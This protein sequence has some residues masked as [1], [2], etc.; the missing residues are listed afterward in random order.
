MNSMKNIF[1]T[2]GLI[3]FAAMTGYELFVNKTGFTSAGFIICAMMV[4]LMLVCRFVIVTKFK[5]ENR[6]TL[7][8]AGESLKTLSVPCGFL[9]NMT[10]PVSALFFVCVILQVAQSLVT[11]PAIATTIVN[12]VTYLI[13]GITPLVFALALLSGR[14]GKGTDF[15]IYSVALMLYIAYSYFINNMISPFT[16]AQLVFALSVWDILSG[17][18]R[19]TAPPP[20]EKKE[21]GKKEKKSKKNK[22]SKEENEV[23]AKNQEILDKLAAEAGEKTEE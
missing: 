18:M 17:L 10:I 20:K 19:K 12:A 21:K 3:L 13:I 2:L 6:E 4:V 15:M 14:Y 22:K 8:A 16:C 23:E 5:E 9:G 11:I 1:C 7:I